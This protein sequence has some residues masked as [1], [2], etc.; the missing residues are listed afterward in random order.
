MTTSFLTILIAFYAGAVCATARSWLLVWRGAAGFSALRDVT[1]I[2]DRVVLRR[3]FGLTHPD[4]CYRVTV[5][6]VLQHRRPA[7]IV[8]TDLPVHLLFLIAVL[9]AW[10]AESPAAAAVLWTAS[11]HAVVLGLAALSV[12]ASGRQ[13]LTD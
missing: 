5:A 9:W 11:A 8:L 6:Q 3:L 10:F 7:G 2:G 13:P 4:G 1:G 12:L